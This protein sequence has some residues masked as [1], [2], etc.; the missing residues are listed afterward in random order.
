MS[1]LVEW[2]VEEDEQKQAPCQH[3]NIV[4][5]H[6]CYCHHPSP[7]APRKCPVY[8]RYGEYPRAWKKMKLICKLAEPYTADAGLDNL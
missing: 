7:D 4:V 2:F 6:A 1:N 8:R 3:G 5:G